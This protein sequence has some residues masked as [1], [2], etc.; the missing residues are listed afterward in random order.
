M[1]LGPQSQSSA[2]SVCGLLIVNG[3]CPDSILAQLQHLDTDLLIAV[4]GGLRHCLALGRQP[5]FLIGDLDSAAAAQISSLE[6]GNTQ[7]IRYRAEK[8]QTDLELALQHA[9]N[10]NVTHLIVAGISGGR[11]DQMLCNWL[12]LGQKRWRFS[13]D[14]IDHSGCGYLVVADKS[15]TIAVEPGVTIS[16][17]SLSHNAGGVTT[18]GLSYPLSNADLALGSSLGIS[19]LAEADEFT[20][21]ISQGVLLAYVNNAA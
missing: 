20:I 9:Q 17:L 19:N 5:D 15:R 4:D 21:S 18:H 3:D 14:V 6:G 10:E 12:L 8:D 7:V 2:D 16:L 11:T 1:Q 13:I